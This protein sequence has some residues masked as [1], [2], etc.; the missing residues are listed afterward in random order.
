MI[1]VREAYHPKTMRALVINEDEPLEEVLHRLAKPRILGAV[2]VVDSE[3]R[4]CG[5]VTRTDLLNYVKVKLGKWDYDSRS[6]SWRAAVKY[7]YA[8]KVKDLVHRGSSRTYV[9]PDDYVTEALDL[10]ITHDLINVPVVD[11]NG[12]ILGDVGISDI[13]LKL[14]AAKS[15]LLSLLRRLKELLFG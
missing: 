4:F 7:I 6:S 12:S 10:M 8:A 2:F 15:L 14:F 9:R 13:L 5:V 3:G 1:T 11:K